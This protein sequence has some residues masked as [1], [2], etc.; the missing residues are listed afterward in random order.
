MR[1]RI[2]IADQPVACVD[3]WCGGAELLTSPLVV[4]VIASL[5]AMLL[6]VVGKLQTAI[7]TC[8]DEREC[9]IAEQDAFRRFQ[10][11]IRQ[12]EP[13]QFES[14]DTA[15]TD[16]GDRTEVMDVPT[17]P[18]DA[19]LKYVL[20]AYEETV[21]SVP[22]YSI[23]DE[24]SLAENLAAELGEDIVTSLATNRVLTPAVQQAIVDRSQQAIDVRAELI[25]VVTE[26]MDRLANYQTELTN[27]ETRQDNLCAHFGSVQMRR[28]EAAFDIWCA[29]QD[30]ETKLDRVA[31]Q[32]QRDLH[33][34]P[35]A[36]PPSEETSDEQ[37]EFCEYLYSDSD[38]PQY[39]VLS[40]IGE[41][42]EAIQTDKEQ[43]R[44]YLG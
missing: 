34:P 33:S 11:Q 32:R 35:V 14:S 2:P 17:S 4:G 3:M 28:R 40:V 26:E 25:E 8:Q 7:E 22:H 44:P 43:I 10:T 42:G 12:V 31:E 23:G 29:L 9:I 37:I 21:R 16:V 5:G 39:P 27:I 20:S 15:P 41:L 6:L 13:V 1:F 38:T 18:G 36:E 24:E 30:L 19:T